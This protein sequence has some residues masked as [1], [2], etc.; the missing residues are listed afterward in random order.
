MQKYGRELILLYSITS[1]FSSEL[2]D[3]S[4]AKVFFKDKS[5]QS[6]EQGELSKATTNLEE[7]DETKQPS[8]MVR[9]FQIHFHCDK[10]VVL[11]TKKYFERKYRPFISS[12]VSTYGAVSFYKHTIRQLVSLFRS[13]FF[14]QLFIEW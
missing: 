1:I 5:K 6:E 8:K 13:F 7:P 3:N 2:N 9:D 11:T 4:A 10:R 12:K 14:S